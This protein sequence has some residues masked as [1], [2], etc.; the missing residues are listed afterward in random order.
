MVQDTQ[1]LL[2][3]ALW[4]WTTPEAT[5]YDLLERFYERGGRVVDT[6]TNY[7]IN[8]QPDDF[9]RAERILAHWLKTNGI[10]DMQ[11]MMKV[12][13]INNMRTPEHNLA[14]SFLL[15]CMDEYAALFGSNLHTL[16]VHWDNRTDA[17]AIA[18]TWEVLRDFQRAGF[19]IGLSGIQHPAVYAGLWSEYDLGQVPIQIKHNLLYSDWERYAPLHPYGK[20]IAYGINA[21]GLKLPSETYAANASLLAR[22]GGLADHQP[23]MD[24]LAAAQKAW[25]TVHTRPAPERMNHLGML[26]AAL[27]PAIGGILLGVSKTEQ[28][29]D[30]FQWLSVL[31]QHDYTDIYRALCR[32]AQEYTKQ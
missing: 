23:L 9:R 8:R 14:P 17:G 27:H 25:T 30:A 16:M 13:S 21:G 18:E 20:F 4:G 15:L 1:L 29:D 31:R 26:Y 28:L 6:A 12:G 11:V 32:I 2:G 10:A 7:P 5:C 24:G 3:T 19:E 22:G